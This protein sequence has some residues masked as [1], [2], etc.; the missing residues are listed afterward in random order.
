MTTRTVTWH[1]ILTG[2]PD[3]TTDLYLPLQS[4]QAT[5]RESTDSYISV[6]V[7]DTLQAEVNARPNGIIEIYKTKDGGTPALVYSVNFNNLRLD[8]GTRS[9]TLTL[10]GRSTASFGTPATVVLTDVV[11][12]NLQTSGLREL[13]IGAHNDIK[14]TDTADYDSVQTVIDLV[15][16]TVNDNG[17]LIRIAE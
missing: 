14:P 9:G 13:E 16:I 11:K 15:E 3:S 17:T 6:V 8:Q 2:T 12:D 4:I 10:S 7:S 5:L 1:G